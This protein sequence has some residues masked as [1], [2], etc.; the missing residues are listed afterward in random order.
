MLI[1]SYPAIRQ[2]FNI[3]EALIA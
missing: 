1:P 3:P 2:E